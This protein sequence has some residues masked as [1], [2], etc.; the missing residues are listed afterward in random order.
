MQVVYEKIAILDKYPVLASITAG[1]SRAINIWT[2]QYSL[3]VYH[4]SSSTVSC[5]TNK[6]HWCV[7][8]PRMHQWILF[9]TQTD[10]VTPKTNC[11]KHFDPAFGDP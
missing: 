2:V 6:I 11:P 4:V 8:E 9:V 7:A 10:D 5:Y 1:S 3:L